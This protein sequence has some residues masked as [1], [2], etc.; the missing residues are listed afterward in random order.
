MVALYARRNNQ[1]EPYGLVTIPGSF[2]VLRACIVDESSTYTR[3]VTRQ[4]P[5]SV[6]MKGTTDE[7]GLAAA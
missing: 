4:R 6:K 7:V 1:T 3:A 5:K 2:D